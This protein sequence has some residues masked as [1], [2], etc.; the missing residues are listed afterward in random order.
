MGPKTTE[1]SV[2]RAATAAGIGLIGCV[3]IWV[4]TPYNNFVLGLSFIADSYLPVAALFLILVLV[5]G[6]NP[7]LR[8][9]RPSLALTRGQ[10][11]II[12]GMM[13]VACVV[14]G[15]G[16]LRVLPYSLAKA[17]LDVR[18]NQRYA[19]QY[20]QMDLP[21][22]L[23]PDKMAYGADTPVSE[24]FVTELPPGE[25]IPWGAWLGPLITW[26]GL[27]AAVWLLMVGLALIVLPQWRR[28]ER[29]PFPLLTIQQRL[30]EDPERDRILPPLF[31]SKGFW[32]A[33]GGV[34]LLHFLAGWH[35]YYPED[36]PAVA[37]QW[38]LRRLFTEAPLVHLPGH[39]VQSRLFFIFLG[40]AF[41]MPSRIG[42]SIWFFTLA[43][44]AYR[45]I[46]TAYFPPYR[47]ST[48][49]DHR[50]G[51]MVLLTL[52][53]LWL[54]RKHW[55][56]VFGSL[57][58]RSRN[59][60][61]LR[62]RRAAA[63]FLTGCAGMFAWL[64]WVGVHPGWAAFY[65]GF[66][67]MICLVITRLVAETG[68]PFLRLNTGYQT[69]FVEIMPHRLLGP[70]SLYF[71]T[72]IAILFP[73][74]SRVSGTTMAAHAIGLD[75]KAGAR[76]HSWMAIGLV[77]VLL[78]GLVISGAANLHGAYHHSTT[79]D[80][81]SQQINSWGMQWLEAGNK[82]LL[83]LES[84]RLGQ[85]AYSP[86]LHIG[87]GAALA[88]VLQW[89]CLALPKWPLHPIGLLMVNT[90]YCQQAWASVLL[91]WMAKVLVLRY[92]GARLYRKAMPA[93]MGLIIGE[94]FAAAYWGIDASLR[95]VFG[96]PYRLVPVLP[97]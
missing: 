55:A 86:P 95:A 39:V 59:G 28:N 37:L 90:W 57:F 30:I 67:F 52:S 35:T 81:R 47:G 34:F 38:N 65:V 25:S 18:N 41:F 91:G 45:V 23:F 80:G 46:A 43:Y 51:A 73:M 40:V 3:L 71:S 75:E 6:V 74:A 32:I 70:V 2:L 26:G 44:A 62:N 84:G 36:V 12:L 64:V 53:I 97:F 92:G 83:A 4:A 8:L 1:Q 63:M 13:L 77:G 5:L 58:R 48:I 21:A 14:P 49:T 19:E 24:Y 15:Q 16:L 88:G 31:H 78:L 27:L 33:A 7:L 72:V 79:L 94:V 61:M 85:R 93:F 10:L 20:Q 89:A 68:M 82:D 56:A 60:E 69:S 76:R 22:S 66:G 87:F 11:A 50:T 9:L 42:F 17:P 54:G 96:M 29:L